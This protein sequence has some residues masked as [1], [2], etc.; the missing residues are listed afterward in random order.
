[1][2]TL[3][4]RVEGPTAWLAVADDG[5]GIPA[6][7]LRRIFEAGYSTKGAGRG[8]GLAIVRESVAAQGGEIEAESRPG[9]G[10]EF[11]IGL[12]LAPA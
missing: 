8:L 1:M 5:P 4:A 10:T 11:R 3:R 2:V 6:A 12:P 7:D 9:R